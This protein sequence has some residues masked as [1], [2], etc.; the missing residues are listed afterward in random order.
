MRHWAVLIALFLVL[1]TFSPI[2]SARQTAEHI[3]IVTIDPDPSQMVWNS[4]FNMSDPA[5]RALSNYNQTI[6]PF[7]NNTSIDGIFTGT[8]PPPM[9]WKVADNTSF[10]QFYFM[11]LVRFK[12]SWI[13]S[14]SS[15]SWWR[16]PVLNI[17]DWDYLTLFIY[18]VGNPGLLRLDA[19]QPGVP[20][21]ASRPLWVYS[22]NYWYEARNDTWFEQNVTAWGRDFTHYWLR[23][24][25]PIHSDETYLVGFYVDGS[26]SIPDIRCQFAQTD[27]SEDQLYE[28]Y[29][30]FNGSYTTLEC[31]LDISVIHQYGMGHTVSGWN[32][33]L[34]NA[35]GGG[36]GDSYYPS[37]RDGMTE[38]LTPTGTEEGGRWDGDWATFGG[39]LA[40]DAVEKTLGSYSIKTTVPSVNNN[41]DYTMDTPI[42]ASIYD[43][44]TVWIR[45]TLT[46][47]RVYFY[48]TGGGYYKDVSLS[49]S[50]WTKVV[51]DMDD[52][53]GWSSTGTPDITT[54]YRFI[55]TNLISASAQLNADEM[56]F[57]TEGGGGGGDIN[58]STIL[59]YS[60]TS[61]TVT[62]GEYVTFMMPF[63]KDITNDSNAKVTI[64]NRN[65]TWVQSFWV[66]EKGPTD[67]AIKSWLWSESHSNKKFNINVTLQNQTNQIFIHDPYSDLPPSTPT[68]YP[69][70]QFRE[71]Y[72]N[73][74]NFTTTSGFHQIW[75]RP[76]HSLQVTDGEWVNTVLDP[77]YFLDGRLVDPDNL[78]FRDGQHTDSLVMK[79]IDSTID[80]ALLV[81]NI[82]DILLYDKLP[83]LDRET[84]EKYFVEGIKFLK[85]VAEPIF[86]MVGYIVEA[87]K[88]VVDAFSQLAGYVLKIISL[89]IFLPFF[90]FTCLVTNGIKR[91]FVIMSRDGPEAAADYGD[92]FLKNSMKTVLRRGQ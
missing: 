61:E 9:V 63:M 14:G 46:L 18:H 2:V 77:L 7:Q 75:F 78:K 76:Y 53:S 8:F 60:R 35:S 80:S 10:D 16:V 62:N 32:L 41:L 45:S 13:M 20:N 55:L 21:P 84:L 26:T 68:D 36:G 30:Y 27:L 81:Y 40:L 86:V 33:E 43:N 50:T 70:N 1:M 64:K 92:N 69:E 31:D 54:F 79:F 85:G 87:V 71:V 12:S 39:V 58:V 37:S 29:L 47:V 6:V 44:L 90:F 56:Y 48:N 65:G 73:A 51:M 66:A 15:V 17:T 52:W 34:Q 19:S 57:T 83:D 67:F 25:A 24:D 91:F 88:W 42:D 59:F 72:Q 11:Q 4:T 49:A 89:V 82:A 74:T 28:S 22:E 23:V 5:N 38:S 3:Q